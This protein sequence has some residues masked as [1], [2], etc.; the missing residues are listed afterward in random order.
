MNELIGMSSTMT[1]HV[2][3]PN[4]SGHYRKSAQGPEPS[5]HE[6]KWAL[7]LKES[8]KHVVVLP[9]DSSKAAAAVAPASQAPV[10]VPVRDK[11]SRIK[12]IS[13]G[14]RGSR[15]GNFYDL[16]GEVVKMFYNSWGYLDLYL[17]DYTV[18]KDLRDCQTDDFDGKN[19]QRP[20][21]RM[22][23]HIELQQPHAGWTHDNVQE[24]ECIQLFNV[25][26][27]WNQK[28][29]G[30][31]LE[32]NLWEDKN[33][34]DRVLVQ[35]LPDTN[36]RY[37]DIQASKKSYLAN[38]VETPKAETKSSKKRKKN[39]EREAKKAAVND[40]EREAKR[41]KLRD[42][43]IHLEDSDSRDDATKEAAEEGDTEED[44][45]KVTASQVAK[46]SINPNG[47]FDNNQVL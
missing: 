2:V 20:T 44:E 6:K 8:L 45:P 34:R 46:K 5:S 42:S 43:G 31:E 39:R 24:G 32:G 14:D 9:E 13:A 19:A 27:K 10:Q 16:A 11:F 3:F 12:G 26:I 36:K 15:A 41:R 37:A 40:E 21:G 18:N 30:Q 33:Y 17:C 4:A 23:L 28:G 25:R 35:P 47:M 29:T 22:T 1:E 7:S 38:I